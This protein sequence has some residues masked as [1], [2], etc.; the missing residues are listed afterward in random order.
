MLSHKLSSYCWIK[1][2]KFIAIFHNIC[3]DSLL[4]MFCQQNL[5][6]HFRKEEK[7][8]DLSPDISLEDL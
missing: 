8:I 7:E 4:K 1:T 5:A 3:Q 6:V 2:D